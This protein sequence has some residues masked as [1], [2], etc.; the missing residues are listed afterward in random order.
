MNLFIK[1]IKDDDIINVKIPKTNT[2]LDLKTLILS[3][4]NSSLELDEIQLVF[5]GHRLENN[6]TL[7]QSG[8][9]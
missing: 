9:E 1:N 7:R 2:I 8:I 4:I 3:K 6:K 5:S